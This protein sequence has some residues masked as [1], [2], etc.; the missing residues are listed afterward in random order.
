MRQTP[1]NRAWKRLEN[2]LDGRQGVQRTLVARAWIMAAS[3]VLLV[4]VMIGLMTLTER[5]NSMTASAQGNLL[6]EDLD[7][8]D[9]E[10]PD[11]PA[12]RLQQ[13]LEKNMWTPISEGKA[14]RQLVAVHINKSPSRGNKIEGKST[15]L[16]VV[17][18]LEGEWIIPQSVHHK[19]ETWSFNGVDEISNAG[20]PVT[21]MRMPF[22]TGIQCRGMNCELKMVI[23]GTGETS[24]YELLSEKEGLLEFQSYSE[25]YPQRVII[26]KESD[27]KF[28]M[29]ISEG[30]AQDAQI[31]F[32]KERGFIFKSEP[33]TKGVKTQIRRT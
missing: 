20:T 32:F 13:E 12:V 21:S 18:W 25:E 15:A 6:M 19:S 30:Q 27:D 16:E 9:L 14:G 28:L 11:I 4:G 31:L 8:S 24:R 5:N 7:V 17:K 26:R 10:S 22:I 1:D 3:V 2:R 23:D 29:E 33:K